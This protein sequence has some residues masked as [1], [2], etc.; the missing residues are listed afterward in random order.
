MVGRPKIQIDASEFE[1]MYNDGTKLTVI[2]EY[3][4]VST[5]KIRKTR[6]ALNLPK[7]LNT[8]TVDENEFK[9]LFESKMTYNEMARQLGMSR[10][11]VIAIKK[12]LNLPNRNSVH[13]KGKNDR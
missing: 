11:S 10:C 7:R 3:F 12:Q 13:T 9:R 8:V 2:A 4:G 1:T 6:N 5:H